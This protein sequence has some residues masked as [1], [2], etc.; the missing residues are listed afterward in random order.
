M[1]ILVPA[2]RGF[3]PSVTLPEKKSGMGGKS[4]EETI[5]AEKNKNTEKKTIVLEIILKKRE[6][7]KRKEV[8]GGV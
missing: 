1:V 2:R 8:G 7:I 5:N 3:P 6:K 4:W